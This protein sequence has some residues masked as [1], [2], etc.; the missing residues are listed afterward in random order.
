MS[1]VQTVVAVIT[2]VLTVW[3]AF[4]VLVNQVMTWLMITLHVLVGN[5]ASV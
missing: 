3:E 5:V 2:I 4:S 1:A